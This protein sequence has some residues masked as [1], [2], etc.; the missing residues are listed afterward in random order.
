MSTDIIL[1]SDSQPQSKNTMTQFLGE[2]LRVEENSM[3]VLAQ[4][5]NIVAGSAETV[6]VTMTNANG[7]TNSYD[8]PSIGFIQKEIS[9]IDKNFN[10]LTGQNGAESVARLADGTFKKIVEA[11]LFK[12]PRAIGSV[13]VPGK[14]YKRPNWFFENFLN[15][16]LFVNIDVTQYVDYDLQQAFIRRIIINANTP[17][18][19]NYFDLNIKGKNDID[20]DKLMLDLVAN[21]IGY[22]VDEDTVTLPA[23]IVRYSGSFY[24]SN[25]KN[26][27]LHNID[28]TGAT[29][30]TKAKRYTLDTLSY[31]DN[32]SN[33]K[34]SMKLAIG[35][36]I[37]IDDITQFQVDFI[38]L[39]T[40]DVGLKRLSGTSNIGIG[41][42]LSI[43]S[44]PF[45]MK[46]LQ[47]NVNNDERQIIFLKPIDKNFNVTTR[48]FSPG[49]GFYTNDLTID[50]STGTETLESYYKNQVMDFGN[51][52]LSLTKENVIP[53]IYGEKPDAPTLSTDN[54]KVVLVNSQKI[55]TTAVD[56]I[57]KKTA[58]KNSISSEIS[59]LGIAIDKKKQE[60]NTSKFNSDAERNAVKNQLDNLI[61]EKTSKSN[62]YASIVKDLSTISQNPPAELDASKYRVRGFWSIPAPKTSIKT[63]AQNI[64]QFIVSY[65]YLSLNGVAPGTEQYD[66]VDNNG[67]TVRAYYSNWIEQTSRLR[68]KTYDVTSGTYT[69]KVE[70]VQNADEININQLDL[71][72]TKGEK[73]ELRIMSVSEAG[74][75]LNPLTSNWSNSVII[76]FPS[77]LEQE[78]EVSTALKEADAEQIRVNFNQD[79]AAK[80]LDTHLTTSFVQKDKYYAH[81]AE[82]IS[83][84]FFNADGSIIDLYTKIKNLEDNYNSL[85]ALIEK[86]KGVL[87]VTVV[88]SSGNVFNVANNTIVNLFAGYYQ[89]RVS[90]LASTE[91]KGAIFTDIYKIVIENSAASPLQ[92]VSQLP[93]GIDQ[94]LTFSDPTLS[95]ND[96]YNKSRR[97]DIVPMTLSS[98]RNTSTK[99]E[100]KY[101]IQPFQSSQIFSQF[102]Y[103]RYTDIGLSNSLI[104]ITYMSTDLANRNIIESS[105]EPIMTS[106]EA[107]TSTFIWNGQYTGVTPQG[108]G[109]QTDFCI[110]TDHPLLTDGN[111][112]SLT[113]LNRPDATGSY[114][115]YP[116]FRHSYAFERDTTVA[117]YY[118]Q[119]PYIKTNTLNPINNPNAY[120]MKLGFYA[121]DRYLIG[122]KTCGAYLYLAPASY[123]DIIVD[124][125]DYKANRTINF[126]SENSLEIPVIFQHRMTDYYGAGSTGVGRIGGSTNLVNL[127]YS[128]KIGIDI[129]T[130]DSSVFSFDIQVYAKYK[131]DTP[132]EASTL[133]VKNTSALNSKFREYDT[134]HGLI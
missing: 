98:L 11:R 96:D 134:N 1:T 72:I 4:L 41:T 15:P 29:V 128:K 80:G 45:M 38:D 16:L 101:Q 104:D 86:A 52:M 112:N 129:M 3:Q 119:A 126:G 27:V 19:K 77:E 24:V 2:V 118:M 88:D 33:A 25:V 71:S 6:T 84:G 110:H 95:G 40:N 43:S 99:N 111:A 97:Y 92:L 53:S 79:L 107:L 26:T 62:L 91:Q 31:N 7:T 67:G 12:E 70:D 55:N 74:W 35:D 108:N 14:F 65:R 17:E 124:G 22:F 9:R 103:S 89:D 57:K 58:S 82:A 61:S 78:G 69:W 42:S 133:A 90:A 130:Q 75:P 51:A 46:V 93:G 125:T 56:D 32:I 105:W 83:S 85:K 76:D 122:Q 116:A 54:F 73:I 30:S 49:F 50:T 68:K 47:I 87:K 60:L 109:Y 18:A 132:A 94:S 81:T 102:I 120:P 34:N 100:S 123:M 131:A 115:T 121:D 117:G 48:N 23:N 36:I 5:S 13:S 59:Q 37:E 8:L 39:S 20:H 44:T 113:E 63:T 28:T 21:K 10:I 64:V 127:S 106:V 66:F 114:A